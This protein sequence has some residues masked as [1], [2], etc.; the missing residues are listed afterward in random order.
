[1]ARVIVYL[2][3]NTE[4][5]KIISSS[6][7]DDPF[8]GL[9][10]NFILDEI[11][12]SS[13]E[14]PI[15]VTNDRVFHLQARLRGIKSEIYKESVPFKSDAEYNTGFMD[16][17]EAELI[18][19]F[20]WSEQGKP[21]F[22][23]PKGPKAVDYQNRIWKVAPRNLYQNL[24]IELMIDLDLKVVSVQSSAGYGKSFLALAAALY[25]VLE[26]KT[27]QKIFVIKPMIE[28]GQK[29]GYLPGKLEEKMEP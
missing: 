10:D 28:I 29:L 8:A 1:M 20:T 12:D 3:E 4:Q 9:V 7:D 19:C 17:D 18:N 15:L 5:F 13:I 24:A 11:Q 16:R 27:H 21:I 23:G 6:T 22:H 25:Q 14:K 2:V 26:K